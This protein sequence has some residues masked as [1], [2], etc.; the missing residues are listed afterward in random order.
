[1]AGSSSDISPFSTSLKSYKKVVLH[2]CVMVCVC[3]GRQRQE[4][5]YRFDN[6][7]GYIV[8]LSLKTLKTLFLLSLFPISIWLLQEAERKDIQRTVVSKGHS[9]E[10][11]L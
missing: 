5:C 2:H 3:N 10:A 4:D 9:I 7:L 1:M 6:N 11:P 8:A